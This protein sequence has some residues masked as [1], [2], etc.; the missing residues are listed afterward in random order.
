MVSASLM[1]SVRPFLRLPTQG[2]DAVPGRRVSNRHASRSGRVQKAVH[3]PK[4]ELVLQASEK[5]I[6]IKT[7][8]CREPVSLLIPE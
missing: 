7:Y 3:L 6:I 4:G 5:P 8:D 2:R 1:S